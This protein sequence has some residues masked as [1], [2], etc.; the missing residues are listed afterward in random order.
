[1]TMPNMA[2]RAAARWIGL[3]AAV[4]TASIVTFTAPAQAATTAVLP[5]RVLDTRSGLGS[6]GTLDPGET[7]RLELPAAAGASAVALNL[8]TDR[9]AGAGFLS[10]RPCA[11]AATTTSFLNYTPAHPVTNLMLVGLGGGAVCITSSAPVHVIADLMGWFTGTTDLRAIAPVRALD[12]RSTGARL[13]A[14]EVRRVAVRDVANLGGAATAAALNITLDR[15]AADGFVTVFPCTPTPPVASTANFRAGETVAAFTLSALAGNDVC[16]YA[17]APTDLIVDVFGASSGGEVVPLPPARVLDTRNGTWSSGQ[18]RN[19][20]DL[21]VRVAG[22]GGV[23]NG[24]RGALLTVTAV[25]GTGNGYVTA[26]PCD[27]PMPNASVVNL[28]PGVV[29]A[30]LVLAALS[31][32]DGEVCL[33]AS[34]QDGSPIHLLADVVG[35]VTGSVAR[36]APPAGPTPPPAPSPSGRFETLPPGT[37]LPGDAEC[38]ARVRPAPEVRP[39]NAVPNATRGVSAN[40]VYPR[41]TGDFTGT[42]DEILQWAACKWG[43]DEDIVRAQIVKESWWQMSANGDNGESWGLG[44]VRVPYHQSAFE[45][46][47]ARRSSAYNVDYTYAVW[48][49]CYEGELGWLNTVERGRQYAAGDEWG[50]LGVWF[51]GRWYT[52][53]AITYIEG[54]P[55]NGYGD[56]GVRQHLQRRTWEQADFLGGS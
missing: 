20:Q 47:N 52:E 12:T 34:T 11:Q 41:V 45:N 1:M 55:T 30:N 29:R 37:P 18:A 54:G 35:Y 21:R 50:C 56:V 23:P 9:A 38:A 17:S 32:A 26:W 24:A 22:R 7:I 25:D 8:T 5:Q 28:W 6:S 51:S 10:A 13:A 4:V 46:D 19:G 2:A 53:A 48:R 49:A 44:Q 36:P 3:A 14:G 40:D 15:T 16:V 39:S 33:R 42:T 31:D 43:I 27:D